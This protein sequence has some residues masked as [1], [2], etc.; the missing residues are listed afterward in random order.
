MIA[1]TNDVVA[2]FSDKIDRLAAALRAADQR[3]RD[4]IDALVSAMRE[5]LRTARRR[6]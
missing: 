5:F 3:L 4:R 6:P 1:N 2:R